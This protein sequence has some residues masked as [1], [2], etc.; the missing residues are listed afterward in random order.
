MSIGLQI[1]G[2]QLGLEKSRLREALAHSSFYSKGKT[3]ESGNS[4]LVF[5]G[6]YAFKGIL[7][8]ILY[9]YYPLP[10]TQLQQ[11]LGNLTR[12]EYLE[13]LFN[14]WGL[15]KYVRFGG[16]FDVR[17]HKHIFV[18]AILGAISQS[19]EETIRRFVFRYLICN[20]TRPIFE[21]QQKNKNLLHQLYHLAAQVLGEKVILETS[22][23]D[24][25]RF[26]TTV[27]TSGDVVLSREIS[28]SYRYSRKKAMKAAVTVLANTDFNRFVSESDY[29]ERLKQRELEKKQ[30][31]QEEVRKKLAQKEQLKQKRI[32]QLRRLRQARDMQR[33]L[34]QAE[35]KQRKALLAAAKKAK[36]LKTQQPVSANKR[37]FLEDKKK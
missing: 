32:E 34:S 30:F 6:M 27:L 19:D 24:D 28:C 26:I 16:N 9:N 7:A 21:H 37:R 3:G 10:G 22:K 1:L 15:L 18:Y 14:N 35:A 25:D 29:L 31:R 2:A 33:K 13:T 5:A 23:V 11:I 36:E 17:K 12:N 8:D 4:R 20:D